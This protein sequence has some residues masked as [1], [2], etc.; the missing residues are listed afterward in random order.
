MHIRRGCG[1]LY[2]TNNKGRYLFLGSDCAFVFP[3]DKWKPAHHAP[4]TPEWA[5]NHEVVGIPFDEI[6]PIL[7]ASLASSIQKDTAVIKKSRV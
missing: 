6:R 7:C 3:L 4:V 5:G 2:S 1:T